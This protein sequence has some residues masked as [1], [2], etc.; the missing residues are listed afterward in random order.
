VFIYKILVNYSPPPQKSNYNEVQTHLLLLMDKIAEVR[1]MF[2]D[3]Y[4]NNIHA[5]VTEF[6]V[7]LKYE[8]DRVCL[9]VD[10]LISVCVY[11]P[12]EHVSEKNFD[13]V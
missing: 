2:H 13:F 9:S 3:N 12:P 8:Q 4:V 10:F 5:E 6:Q 1:N 7:T 11:L